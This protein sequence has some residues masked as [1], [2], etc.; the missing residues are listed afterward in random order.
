MRRF[1]PRLWPTLISLS[2]L[3]VLL[4]LGVWQLERLEW[5]TALIAA[6]EAALAAPAVELPAV[7]T[8]DLDFRRVRVH[9][10]LLNEQAQRFR[11]RTHNGEPGYEALTPL[12]LDTGGVILVNRG[13]RPEAASPTQ[14]PEGEATLE[15]VLRFPRPPGYFA[16]EHGP[17]P[18]RWLW[19]DL[20]GLERRHGTP[21][22]PAVLE[23]EPPEGVGLVNNHLQ[24]AL[25]WCA[26]AAALVAIYVV[27]LCDRRPEPE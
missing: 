18:E 21:L 2:A 16:P 4:A 11:L 19:Y 14:G 20:A 27:R 17:A 23:L 24:Y 3:G 26:L 10:R 5:K 9:G 6:R 8:P 22:A 1:R 7:L 12:R 13:W 15:G 25:T